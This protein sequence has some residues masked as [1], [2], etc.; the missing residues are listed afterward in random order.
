MSILQEHVN[1]HVNIGEAEVS[2]GFWHITQPPLSD[3]LAKIVSMSEPEK[4][5]NSKGEK[6]FKVCKQTSKLNSS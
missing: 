4:E 2:W 5:R 1:L 6:I 3:V